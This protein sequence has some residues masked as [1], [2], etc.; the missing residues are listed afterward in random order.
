MTLPAD[1]IE[2]T[3]NATALQELL[4]SILS[5][6]D[7]V[8]S[9]SRSLAFS[10][11]SLT[12][13]VASHSLDLAKQS[14]QTAEHSKQLASHSKT[15]TAQGTD[16]RNSVSQLSARILSQEAMQKVMVRDS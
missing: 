8:Q 12:Q 3:V 6:V 16:F 1:L 10:V 9:N 13:Q 4:Q 2:G 7:F 5:A 15:I 11:D 14:E